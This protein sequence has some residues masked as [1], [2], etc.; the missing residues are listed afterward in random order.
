MPT[1]AREDS[2]AIPF[3]QLSLNTQPSSQASSSQSRGKGKGKSKEEMVESVILKDI[4][5][6]INRQHVPDV[7]MSKNDVNVNSFIDYIKTSLLRLDVSLQLETQTEIMQIIF[8]ALRKQNSMDARSPNK[9]LE[10]HT[11]GEDPD[12][13]DD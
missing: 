4:G 1:L 13:E 8:R 2:D 3:S 10:S 9:K 6:Y 11:F 5:H 7:K 12:L